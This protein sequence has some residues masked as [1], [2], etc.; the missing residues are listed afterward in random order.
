MSNKNSLNLV[1]L[2]GR[3]GSDPKRVDFE[4][5]SK[6]Y[7]RLATTQTFKVGDEY[8]DYT[9]WHNCAVGGPSAVNAEKLLHKGDLVSIVG[10]LNS[11]EATDKKTGF[12]YERVEVRVSEFQILSRAAKAAAATL[13]PWGDDDIA[14]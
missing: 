1:T 9:T 13:E 12:K 2:I 11:Y 10:T 6:C 5:G 7:I 4:N 14:L 8:K 3:L